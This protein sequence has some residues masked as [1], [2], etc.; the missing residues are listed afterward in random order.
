MNNNSAPHADQNAI[1][2]GSDQVALSRQRK[3]LLSCPSSSV[4][5]VR[6]RRL[7]RLPKTSTSWS[8]QPVS[9]L[10]CQPSPSNFERIRLRNERRSSLP[11]DQ[12]PTCSD[13]SISPS[14]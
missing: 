11:L 9:V 7:Q 12:Y 4:T 2:A 14:C 10:Y 8:F 6:R 1:R 13:D 5:V 3:T